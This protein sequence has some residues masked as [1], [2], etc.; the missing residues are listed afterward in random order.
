M[1]NEPR[2][3]GKWWNF[4]GSGTITP[5][6]F[7]KKV[8][9][10]AHRPMKLQVANKLMLQAIGLFNPFMRELVEMHYLI[11]DPVIMDDS[12]LRSLLGNVR[13]TPYDEGIR[14][15]LEAEKARQVAATQ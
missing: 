8:F 2:I 13:A 6:D 15:T 14:L 12:P 7:A 3:W 9:E 11:T 4:A 1:L 10:E 5:R